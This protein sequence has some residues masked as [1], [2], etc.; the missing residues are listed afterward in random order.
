MNVRFEYL[1]RDAANYKA[2]AQVIFS[3]PSGLG[4]SEIFRRI[5]EALEARSPFPDLLH[6]YPER[7]GLHTV[8]LSAI[9]GASPDDLDCHEIGE[10]VETDGLVSDPKGRSIDVFLDDLN[11][12]HQLS[13]T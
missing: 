12:T 4:L 2:F 1:Y 9:Y 3:N 8:F 6:F 11:N 5:E 7:V 10:I 13:C